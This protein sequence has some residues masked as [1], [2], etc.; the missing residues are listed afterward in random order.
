MG[1]R[2]AVAGG[3]GYAGGELLRVLLDHPGFDVGPIT[4][5]SHAGSLVTSVH[6]HLLRLGGHTFAATDAPA[7]TDADVVFLALPHGESASV[8]SLLPPATPV[9][10]LGADHR[11]A[12]AEIWEQFYG[13][14]HSGRWT[15]G[16]PEM[17]GARHGIASAR[18]VANPGCHATAVTLALAPLL[19]ERL[20]DPTDLVATAASGTSGAGRAAKPHLLGSEVMGA[21][22][23]YKVGG[24]HQ[25]IPEIE[26]A[27]G[28]VGG[29]PVTLS[30]TPML[31]P[32]PRG[33]LVTATARVQSG[34]G[35]AQLR[36]ALTVS[37][38]DEA[39][40]HVLPEN[41]WPRTDATSG[42]N[43]AHLQLAYDSRV[44]RA[45]VVSAIDNLGKGAAG[46][47]VQNGN[48]MLGLD[49]TTG[50]TAQGLAP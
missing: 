24:V 5:G 6:P 38:R 42:S 9:V 47:A 4:A 50:L 22:S 11:L 29:V 34:V 19:A 8:A 26:Q 3:S 35:A 16:L 36:E 14:P 32:M 31:A 25:H 21:M 37:Y 28:E 12:D 40:V 27:L 20:V 48:L 45:V 30:F 39:F 41:T 7:F 18:R 15:Y 23:P 1:M 49:E 13:S 44:G 2:A 33:I 17:P 46:Q 10:D 43:A